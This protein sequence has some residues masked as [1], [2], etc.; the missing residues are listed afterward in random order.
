[1]AGRQPQRQPHTRSSPHALHHHEIQGLLLDHKEMATIHS[2]LKQELSAV[3]QDL[4]QLASTAHKIREEKESQVKELYEKSLNLESEVRAVETLNSEHAQVIAHVQKLTESKIQL[5]S[6]FKALED[7]LTR[8][9]ADVSQVSVI[10][11]DVENMKQELDKGRAAVEF[12]KKTRA[13]NLELSQAMERKMNSLQREIEM[14]R[15]EVPN[16]EKRA[17]A[18]AAVS[19]PN[20]GYMGNYGSHS[21]TY[22]GSPY[23]V[24]YSLNQGQ[25]TADAPSPGLY[26]RPPGS[27]G[28]FDS[29]QHASY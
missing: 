6:Q 5:A 14:L 28:P 21:M 23:A 2:S 1:M 9:K 22:G 4:R 8:V 15:A 26:G 17:R 29:Q 7:E 3:D 20:P 11:A 27:Q 13:E 12:E 24:Q 18:A 16:A 25:V 10:K 19:N